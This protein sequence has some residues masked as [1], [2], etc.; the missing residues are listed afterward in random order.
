MI[1]LYKIEGTKNICSYDI[2][3]S[4]YNSEL[5]WPNFQSDFDLFKE[6]IINSVDN[7]DPLLFTRVADGEFRFLERRSEGTNIGNRH[8][9]KNIHSVDMEP[10]WEGIRQCDY[11]STQ[12]YTEWTDEFRRVINF[13]DIDFPMEFAYSIVSS[14]WIFEKYPDSIGIIGGSEKIKLIQSLMEFKEYRDYLGVDKF[15]DYI[16]VPERYSSD[17]IQ[18]LETHIGKELERST[19]NIFIFGIGIS[20]LAVAHKFKKYHKATY[21]DVGCGISALAG[22]TALERPYFGGWTNFII[23]GYD[24]SN[25]DRMDYNDTKGI[26]EIILK[27]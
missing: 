23:D 15:T 26:N 18:G 14:K 24:Y 11:I 2:D 12:L 22:T 7:K 20:K 4:C 9:S 3:H 5:T 6:R 17:D 19:A 13:R 16:S 25:I 10:F 8:L 1:D 21:I 27:K